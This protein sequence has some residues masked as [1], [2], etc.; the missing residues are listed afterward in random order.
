MTDNSFSNDNIK[1]FTGNTKHPYFESQPNQSNYNEPNNLSESHN[2]SWKNSLANLTNI[3]KDFRHA[4]FSDVI[5]ET[6]NSRRLVLLVVFIALFFD[7]ML[8]TTVGNL[9]IKYKIYI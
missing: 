9:R 5:K 6:R 1:S 8:L 4:H 7:N 2:S 3:A